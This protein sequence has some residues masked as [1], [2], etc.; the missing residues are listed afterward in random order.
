LTRSTP[1]TPP[2]AGTSCHWAWPAC[3]PWR[4]G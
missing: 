3:R 4:R 2:S 1:C